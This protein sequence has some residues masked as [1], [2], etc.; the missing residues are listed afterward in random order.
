MAYLHAVVDRNVHHAE[1]C[2]HRQMRYKHKCAEVLEMYIHV[3]TRLYKKNATSTC[4]GVPI[5]SCAANI[6]C[7]VLTKTSASRFPH[8][9]T[10]K[11]TH[12]RQKID[13]RVVT[14]TKE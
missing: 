4:F 2:A 12:N 7:C 10:H 14:F 1:R 13:K 6:G 11:K 9:Q 3:P 8:V 5:Y